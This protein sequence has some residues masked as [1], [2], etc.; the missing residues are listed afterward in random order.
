MLLT[1]ALALVT[2]VGGCIWPGGDDE[3]SSCTLAAGLDAEIV[4]ADQMGKVARVADQP[5]VPLVSAPQG[6]HILL[7]GARVH[8]Q[9]PSCAVEIN[10]ALRD[11]VTNRV[12][13]LEE[14]PITIANHGDDWAG[15][16]SSIGLSD[17]ANVAVCPQAAVPTSIDGHPYL[18]EVRIAVSGTEI[19][20]ASAT[21][22]PTC[23]DSYC[24]S[25]CAPG[26]I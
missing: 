25:D 16:P 4:F 19:A 22:T 2:L 1:R 17:L 23:S 10:A 20:H 24:H 26:G 3:P 8:A 12:I 11:P 14:R 18:V 21:I 5:N 9:V 7:I 6:G 13:G 15:P